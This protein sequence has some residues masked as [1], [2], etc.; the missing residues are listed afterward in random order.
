MTIQKSQ[1]MTGLKTG[2]FALMAIGLAFT[3]QASPAAAQSSCQGSSKSK[4]EGSSSC[5]WVSGYKTKAGTSVKSYCRA[6][7]GKGAATKGSAKKKAAAKK[8][9]GK[10]KAESKKASGK[11]KGAKKK[12][13]STKKASKKKASGKKKTAR[14]KSKK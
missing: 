5:S 3:L 6:N 11:S 7:P 12:A 4:C 1:Y 10:S 9:S 13:S 8:A 14:K 2:L